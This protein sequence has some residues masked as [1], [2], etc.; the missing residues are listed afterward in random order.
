MLVQGE[1]VWLFI[2]VMPPPHAGFILAYLPRDESSP[3]PSQLTSAGAEKAKAACVNNNI[4]IFPYIFKAILKYITYIYKLKYKGLIINITMTRCIMLQIV[5]ICT[6]LT[7]WGKNTNCHDAGSFSGHKLSNELL[8]ATD[9]PNFHDKKPSPAR[10]GVLTVVL[11]AGHGGHDP[12]CIG[13]HSREKEITLGLV[14]KLGRMLQTSYP[15]LKII[16]TRTT[17]VFVPLHERAAIANKAQADVFISI[18]CNYV[19]KPTVAGSETYV[20]G[21]HTA[22]ENLKVAK[23]ENAAILLEEDY[24]E[25]YDGF[26]PNSP[27]GHII[28]SM[29]QNAYLEKS[30]QLAHFIEDEFVKTA[31]RHSRGVKQA[32]F[33]V[34]RRT[35]MPSV[36]VESGFLSNRQEE[37]YLLSEE[38]QTTMAECIHRAFAR[39]VQALPELDNPPLAAIQTQEP[40]GPAPLDV[41]KNQS[42]A[43]SP[44]EIVYRVQLGASQSPELHKKNVEWKQ[45][46]ELF[47]MQEGK[48]YKYLHG[49]FSRYEDAQAAKAELE[50]KGFRGCFVVA[51]RENQRIDVKQAIS[52]H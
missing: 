30:I 18:H 8:S 5:L 39:Y 43:T 34:L 6:A 37:A 46:S 11:D 47:V 4:I 17:D 12:G 28:L 24:G 33:L 13:G 2:R 40:E 48:L 42:V 29:Y 20:M 38:G 41:V 23:R 31:K 15:E 16:Y 35:S 36:L 50:K 21:L 22:E 3:G 25:N 10:K 1:A 32:G 45:V 19:K 51:Y 14:K 44:K 52:G 7:A 27:E 49:N 26:D 9:I